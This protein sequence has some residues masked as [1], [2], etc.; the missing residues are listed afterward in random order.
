MGSEL[1]GEGDQSTCPSCPALIIFLCTS[2]SHSES[3]SS[4]LPHT[5]THT[6]NVQ[7]FPGIFQLASV[8][9]AVMLCLGFPFVALNL[10]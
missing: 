2:S 3:L 6:L 7:C 8:L 9:R 10:A 4:L 5:H 1:G